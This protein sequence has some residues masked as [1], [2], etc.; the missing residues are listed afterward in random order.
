MLMQ[1]VSFALDYEMDLSSFLTFVFVLS[2]ILFKKVL[3]NSASKALK[4]AFVM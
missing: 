3:Y 4:A 1:V 2:K